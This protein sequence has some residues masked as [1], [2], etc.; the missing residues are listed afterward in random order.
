MREEWEC[1]PEREKIPFNDYPEKS[2]TRRAVEREQR[3]V[4]EEL[5]PAHRPLYTLSPD[6]YLRVYEAGPRGHEILARVSPLQSRI[7]DVVALSMKADGLAQDNAP[8]EVDS[9]IR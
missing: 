4:V 1:P 8:S 5:D 6:R 2:F 7:S 3:R 9:K